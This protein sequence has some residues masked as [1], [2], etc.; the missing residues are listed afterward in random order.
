MRHTLP[1]ICILISTFAAG[2]SYIPVP[3]LPSLPW[4]STELQSD[5]TAEAI[6]EQGMIHFNNKAY[7][8][9]IAKFEKIR[10][11]FPFTPQALE[12]ELKIA[13]TS[14]HLKQYPQA[15][16]AFEEFHSMH[17]TNENIPF[18]IYY[19][20]LAHF[21]QFTSIDRDQKNTEIAK[22]H[23]E[24]VVKNHPSS[25]YASQAKEKLAKCLEYLAEHELNI[26]TFYMR[27]KNYPAAIDRLEG[28]VRR[29]PQ[30]PTAVKSLY[31]L[32][33]S[34]RLRKN[35]VKAALAYEALI[36]HY[37][38]SPLAKEARTHLAQLEKERQDPL[39][40]LLMRDRRR[41]SVPPPNEGSGG[42]QNP[43]SKIQNRKDLNLVAKKEV[44]H[45]EPGEEKGMFRRVMDTLNPFAS[46]EK[47]EN[48]DRKTETA[49]AKEESAKEESDG[50]FASLWPFGKKE[51][52]AKAKVG[53][54]RNLQLVSKIDE[55]LKQQGINPQSS[56]QGPKPPA[57][58]LPQIAEEP[59]P[60]PADTAE[61]LGQ[62]D[63]KLKK[64]GKEVAD[65][66]PPP[67]VAPALRAS[68][69][70]G[71]KPA[72]PKAETSPATSGLIANIDEKL[73]AKGIE[74][75]QIQ[76]PS[77]TTGT[78]GDRPGAQGSGRW[79]QREKVELAPRLPKEDKPFF[80]DPGEYRAPEAEK[81]SE[82]ASRPGGLKASQPPKKLPQAVM[83]NPTQPQKKKPPETKVA[84]K[85]QLEKG[86]EEEKGGLDQLKEDLQGLRDLMNPFGW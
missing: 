2:C 67:E 49:K 70:E 37:P 46:S 74:P 22:G 28:I 55:S 64:E 9:A 44:V 65:L 62:I 39:A 83:K 85:K 19:L 71:S 16:S 1:T 17:P 32:G 8:R 47:K 12:A 75:P 5:P 21:D 38:E 78:K 80:I 56:G 86:E 69:T 36:Q 26:A 81:G 10:D 50:F 40:M 34:Y 30:T 63:S 33:E 60:P 73:N 72:T 52:K 79:K 35:S 23:F 51:E 82:E 48:G 18:V 57:S 3:S 59:I 6:F 84:E 20:G 13:E 24:S 27:A 4:S 41:A 29:Y 76:L 15:I 68:S 45:E 77:P 43:K 61:L 54:A 53:A 58:D 7:R 14:Y 31:H 66:P 25:P 42:I 11:E